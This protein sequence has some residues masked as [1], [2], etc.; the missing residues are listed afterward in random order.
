MAGF[1]VSIHGRFWVSAEA[2]QYWIRVVPDVQLQILCANYTDAAD[3]TAFWRDVD[4]IISSIVVAAD[5]WQARYKNDPG[6]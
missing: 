5:V 4:Q 3:T 1:Q 2:R 6:P